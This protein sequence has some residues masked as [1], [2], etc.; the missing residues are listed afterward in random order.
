VQSAA[1][2]RRR[3]GALVP[4]DDEIRVAPNATL[5]QDERRLNSPQDRAAATSAEASEPASPAG[6]PLRDS[7]LDTA[8]REQIKAIRQTTRH[9]TACM[10][11]AP[12]AR[13]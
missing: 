3:P 1:N 10:P 9:L 6:C 5:A 8:V 12:L 4:A 13:I 7:Q 2:P 11:P